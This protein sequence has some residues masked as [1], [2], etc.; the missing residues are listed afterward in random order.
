MGRFPGYRS[1][2]GM[3]SIPIITPPPIPNKYDIIPIHASDVA[4]FLRCRRYWDWS[5]PA[6]LNLRRRVDINGV[7]PNLWFGTGIHYALEM[8]Y[9]PYLQRDPVEAWLEWYHLQWEGG[10]VTENWLELTYDAHPEYIGEPVGEDNDNVV[11]YKIRGLRD[12]HPNPDPEE[13]E[14]YKQLGVGMLN[15]YKEYAAKNDNFVVIAAES[16]FSIP[17]GFER[18]DTREESPN[19]GKL[20]EVHARGKRDAIIYY[21][22]LERFGIMDHKT[23]AT[24]EEEY[25]VKLENDPQ[26][27][28]YMWA[29]QMEAILHDLPYTRIDRCLYNVL[30]KAYPKPPT[31][32]KDGI[33]PSV[34]RKDECTTAE[35]FA[36]YIKSAGIQELYEADSK[37]QAYYNWLVER[38]DKLF[39]ER[40]DVLRNKQQLEAQD[41]HIKAI[42]NE[43]LR[44][45]VAIYPTPSSSYS[46]TRC[47]FRVPCLLAD[48][49]GAYIETLSDSY[50][51]NKGR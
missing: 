44:P 4:S 1:V 5:S 14:G 33:S 27:S 11:L 43:M 32:L 15:F 6:R 51:E 9:N 24:M 45:D 50:E 34:N 35:L 17:L 21:P 39:V 10:I 29:S 12:I 25:F 16:T 31:I 40:R 37:W 3:A 28:T 38:G 49:G 13:F 36:E 8:Y 30:R 2:V 47:Q 48:S 7:N 26:V 46:C 20:V 42:A 23:A 22:H 19:Y 18:V 41:R